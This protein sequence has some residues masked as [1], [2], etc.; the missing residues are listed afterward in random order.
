VVVIGRENTGILLSRNY[1][2]ALQT[3]SNY[4]QIRKGMCHFHGAWKLEMTLTVVISHF[5]VIP[6]VNARLCTRENYETRRLVQI[7]SAAFSNPSML[8]MV[9]V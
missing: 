8:L 4:L 6:D 9:W 5:N 2:Y 1:G 3:D 7:V